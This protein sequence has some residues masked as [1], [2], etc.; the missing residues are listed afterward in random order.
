[1]GLPMVERMAVRM[2]VLKADQWVDWKVDKK[3]DR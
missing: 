1:L 2:V 3:D